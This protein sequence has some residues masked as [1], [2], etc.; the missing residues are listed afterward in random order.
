MVAVNSALYRTIWRWH[1]YAGLFVMP[2]VVILSITGA[3]YLFKPQIDHWEER[4][5]RELPT[6]EAV[7]ADAQIMAALHAFP[8]AKLSH[9]R[10]PQ[11]LGDAA[12]V[13]LALSD[14]AM[15]DVFVSPQGRVVGRLD[16]GRRITDYISA[17]H[18]QLMLGKRGSWLVE[19]AASW[20]IVLILSGL[21]LW[22]PR[23]RSGLTGIVW[24][25]FRRGRPVWRDLHAVTG[26]WVSG[27][28]L[29]LLVSGLPWAA[30]WGATFK[31]VRDQLGLVQD[32]QDWTIGGQAVHAEHDHQAMIRA[33]AAP[34]PH[35]PLAAI[36]AKATALSLAAPVLIEP[37]GIRQVWTVKSDAQSR[38]LRQA[39]TFDA[40]TGVKRSHT[41]FADRHWVDRVVGY[42]IAWHEGALFGWVNQLI[43]LLTAAAMLMMT[44]SAFILWRRRKPA[45]RLG[46]PSA[47][48]V[49]SRF[50]GVVAITIGLAALLPLLALSL[51]IVWFVER[52]ILSRSPAAVRWLGLADQL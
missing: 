8:G 12:L 18:G 36:V 21:Y 35:L 47:P 32:K 45:G 17:I 51:I 24:P 29:L 4:A 1:F 48:T 40:V 31:V 16:P 23:S 28:A 7:D 42:G 30:Q 34:S 26:F 9:Y 52:V 37:P 11:A 44:V 13:H 50:G 14:G 15:R 25:R 33:I 38:P 49:P 5:F 6:A 27:L 19:L 46:A 10:L 41:R 3:A 22:W 20:T 39:L 43:G 2:F